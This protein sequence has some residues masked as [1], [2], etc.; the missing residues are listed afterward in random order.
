[1][2]RPTIIIELFENN[3]EALYSNTDL[4]FII[5]NRTENQNETTIS[6]PH[7]PTLEK[8]DLSG[9]IDGVQIPQKLLTAPSSQPFFV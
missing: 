9:V 8:S 6:G 2:P 1:M 5:V 3:F 4:S 7:T